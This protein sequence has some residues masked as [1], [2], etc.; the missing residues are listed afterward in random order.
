MRMNKE[1]APPKK[2][3]QILKGKYPGV[4]C[5]LNFKTPW[6]LLVAT[7][8]SA[9]CTDVR[10]NLVTGTLFEKY[11]D[12][13]SIDRISLEELKQELRSINFFNNKSVFIKASA[14]K[15]LTEFKGEVPKTMA[16]LITLPGV[17]RKTANVVL[18]EAFHINTGI[19]V[20]THVKRVSARL[21]WTKSE[22]PKKI[23]LE[24]M[25]LFPNIDWRL[26]SLMLILH[27]REICIARKPKCSVCPLRELCPSAED[28]PAA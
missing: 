16:E 17:A 11:P 26:V 12:A 23:E 7:I 14:R 4:I 8:L 27:G 20:D 28:D 21:G 19:A 5:P 10:V 15:I 22:D 13:L 3:M 6:Q 1:P 9:Q 18:A 2:V 25:Q 24:L